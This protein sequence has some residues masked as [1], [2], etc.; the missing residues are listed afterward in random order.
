[1]EKTKRSAVVPVDMGWSDLGSWDAIWANAARDANGN[2]LSG[3]CEVL[4]VKNT[5]VQSDDSMLTT[6]IGLS[7]IMVVSSADAVLVAP[8]DV[9]GEIKTLVENLKA[10]GR[11]EAT[12]HR[13][14]HRPWGHY[15]TMS[16]GELHRVNRILINPGQRFSLQ[17]HYHRSEH[18]I[19][20]KG[21][22]EITVNGDVRILHENE[23]S[24]IPIGAVH[25]LANP[26]LIPLELIEV[27]V[28]TYLGEDDIVRLEDAYNRLS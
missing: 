28:G 21:T 3:P 7:D 15:V 4:D 24:Y 5:I 13:R 18:W 23:S 1:M 6:V 8:R 27:Q 19:I 14:V 20:V 12:E 22:G 11:K 17:K 26:G 16:L 10:L 2:A 9:T 25:R